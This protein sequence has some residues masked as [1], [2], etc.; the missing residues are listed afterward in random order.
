M[1]HSDRCGPR[2]QGVHGGGSPEGSGVPSMRAISVLSSARSAE[3]R[4]NGAESSVSE[5][6]RPISITPTT[7]LAHPFECLRS[8]GEPLTD[9][10]PISSSIKRITLKWAGK[11]AYGGRQ[12]RRGVRP[13]AT[14]PLGRQ[15]FDF[16]H[17]G[18]DISGRTLFRKNRLA[19]KRRRPQPETSFVYASLQ[20]LGH[21]RLED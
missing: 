7:K 20:S 18:D 5:R 14:W 19:A 8:G 3:P 13:S 2:R 10:F 9:S 12:R 6:L 1:R 4:C 17:Q 15:G 11:R 16:S 21:R